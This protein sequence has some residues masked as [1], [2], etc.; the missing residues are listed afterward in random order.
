M[1]SWCLLSF[2]FR[3]S[4]PLQNIGISSWFD[5]FQFAFVSCCSSAAYPE[6]F[7]PY[8]DHF[9]STI[10]WSIFINRFLI[11][12]CQPFLTNFYQQAFDHLILTS[13]WSIFINRFL[14]LFINR[15]L[16]LFIDQFRSIL[17]TTY[18][19]PTIWKNLWLLKPAQPICTSGPLCKLKALNRWVK[20]VLKMW[21][22]HHSFPLTS[23]SEIIG[24]LIIS[25]FSAKM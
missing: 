1:Y 3:Y 5:P 9:L 23:G 25:L 24:A 6:D 11:N 19:K 22:L 4:P 14:F 21:I 2:L 18:C 17:S 12:F 13:F 10:C 16:S 8:Y 20:M 7:Q 15:F